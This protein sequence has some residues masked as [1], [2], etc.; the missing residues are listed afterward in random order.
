MKSISAARA[1]VS[2]IVLLGSTA[3]MAVP[4]HHD[5]YEGI[6][7]TEIPVLGE[8]KTILGQSFSYPTGAPK[9]QN[10]QVAI[11]QGKPTNVHTHT[12]P[13]LVYVVSGQLEV[14]YGSKGKKV[15][16]TGE[17][18]VEAIN[19]CHQGRAAGNKPVTVQV[20]YLGQEGA[21]MAKPTTCDKLN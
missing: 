6:Q 15:I 17:S 5:K 3:V 2:A 12:I 20:T 4:T 13:V 21:D 8:G 9:I 16:K 10:Y 1:V 19:W 14:D 18:Y 11:A 7:A